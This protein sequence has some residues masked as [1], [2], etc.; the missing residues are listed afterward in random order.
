MKKTVFGVLLTLSAVCFVGSSAQAAVI[1][2]DTVT[3][4]KEKSFVADVFSFSL[5]STKNVDYSAFTSSGAA[6]AFVQL[7]E[8]TPGGKHDVA[9]GPG[10]EATK[11]TGGD[12][13]DV[14]LAPGKY[15]F[16]VDTSSTVNNA[17]LT[18]DARSLAA[19][20]EP[21]IYALMFAGLLVVGVATRRR[22]S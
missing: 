17:T 21:Q 9:I 20:P 22:V 13:M 18:I 2:D 4:P 5:S 15:F 10:F 14:T 16:L 11:K 12:V 7:Y 1:L 19:V 8:G 6:D 3:L